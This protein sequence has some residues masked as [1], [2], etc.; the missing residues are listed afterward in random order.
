MVEKRS[1][2]EKVL[3]KLD[4]LTE[5]QRRIRAR[6]AARAVARLVGRGSGTGVQKPSKD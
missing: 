1:R 2:F 6:E 3:E 5:E 4:S